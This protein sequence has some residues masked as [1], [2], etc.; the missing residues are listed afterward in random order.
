MKDILVNV[1][2]VPTYVQCHGKWLNDE[3]L[4]NL[5]EIVLLLPGNPGFPDLYQTFVAKIHE[6]LG[7]VIPVWTISYAGHHYSNEEVNKCDKNNNNHGD[8]YCIRKV[9]KYH[10]NEGLFNI[11]GQSRH[12]VYNLKSVFC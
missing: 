4:D 5:K 9:P 10:G 3:N 12:K 8:D 11:N 2:N 7:R 6:N 1:L